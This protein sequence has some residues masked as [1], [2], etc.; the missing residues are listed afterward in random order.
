MKISPYPRLNMN[1]VNRRDVIA[2]IGAAATTS[3]IGCT[4]RPGGP[5]GLYTQQTIA[6]CLVSPEQTQGPFFVEEKLNRSDL[7]S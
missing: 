2:L 5:S 4:R 1:P 3:L 6:G 7:A